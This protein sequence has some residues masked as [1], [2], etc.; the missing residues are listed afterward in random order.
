MSLPVEGENRGYSY[1]DYLSWPEDGR[2]EI[3]EGVAYNMTPAPSRVHQEVLIALASVFYNCLKNSDCEIY[4]APFDVRLL[5]KSTDPK[6]IKTVVQP[7]II[8]VCDQN[9][10]DDAG[11]LGSPDLV[12]EIVSPSTAS[13]DYIKKL[14]LYE[15]HG[16][17][18]YWI[19]HPTD[20]IVMV[21]RLGNDKAYG[22][23]DIYDRESK[24]EVSAVRIQED[25]IIIDLQE[26]FK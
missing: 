15:K 5:D 6:D 23:P 20:R 12:V 16:V 13:K 14:A 21:Y 19:V 17:K 1:S 8:V 9:K 4:T 24:V 18:E 11:C 2:W 26:V 10:L 25:P 3:I 22:K 7:D